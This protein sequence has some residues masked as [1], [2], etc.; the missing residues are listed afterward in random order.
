MFSA[1]LRLNSL[2]G[3]HGNDTLD[4]RDGNDIFVIESGNGENTITDF[5]LGQ[6]CLGLTGY[7]SYEDLTFSGSKINFG[8]ELLVTVTGVDTKH[9]TNQDFTV[10]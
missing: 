3:G 9:L 1:P 2:L 4:G 5:E 6:D 10:I 8:N 7:L